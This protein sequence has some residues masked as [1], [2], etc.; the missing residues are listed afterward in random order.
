L[1]AE[2]TAAHRDAGGDQVI[3]EKNGV[4]LAQRM[5]RLR[6]Q[7][8]TAGEKRGKKHRPKRAA[9]AQAKHQEF[10]FNEGKTES[11]TS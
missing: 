6:I 1:R 7:W 10:L 2:R 3:R 4:A 5:H 11:K 8:K 9:R